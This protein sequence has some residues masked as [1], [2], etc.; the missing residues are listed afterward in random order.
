MSEQLSGAG[1]RARSGFS[2]VELTVVLAVV[3]LI[4]AIAVPA[5]TSVRVNTAQASA[6]RSAQLLATN[7]LALAISETGT[8]DTT[9]FGEALER[10]LV[11]S[12]GTV[13]PLELGSVTA[14]WRYEHPNTY[15]ALITF[16]AQSQTISVVDADAPAPATPDGDSDGGGDTATPPESEPDPAPEPVAVF[17]WGFNSSGQV[18]D[19]TTTSAPAPVEITDSG[20]LDGRRVTAVQAG[21]GFSVALADDGTLHAWGTDVDGRLGAGGITGSTVPVQIG[22]TGSLAGRQIVT[23]EVGFAHVLVI[24]DDGTL[25]GWGLNNNDQL[26]LGAFAGNKTTPHLIAG[27]SLDGRT[28]VQASAGRDHSFAITSDGTVHAWGRNNLGQLG[29]GT[30]AGSSLPT[31]LVLAG[32]LNGKTVSWIAARHQNSF[33]AATDGTFHAW[34][35]AGHGQLG[36]GDTTNELSP[37]DIGNNGSFA[38][39]TVTQ[40]RGGWYHTVALTS[41]GTVHTFGWSSSGQLGAGSTSSRSVPGEVDGGSLATRTVTAIDA[42]NIFSVALGA[43]GTVHTWGANNRD[44]LGIAGGNR[45]LP[46]QVTGELDGESVLSVAAGAEHSV[47]RVAR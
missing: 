36:T 8:P 27:G 2:L 45:N 37:V 38:G 35:A 4:A 22:T 34:G 18:G 15:R 43:D 33:A 28:V 5:Y 20:S 21:D 7:A 23:F 19:G 29:N 41:D 24:A 1:A 10:A 6:T 46:A 11:E 30:T 39:R 44:Q 25:H 32:S 17:A 40:I 14:T 16:D 3:A 26:G 47:V 12:S 9:A 13:E 31:E 42:G